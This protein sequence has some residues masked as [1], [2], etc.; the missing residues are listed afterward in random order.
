MRGIGGEFRH[1]GNGD[2]CVKPETT[3]SLS[4]EDGG[5]DWSDEATSQGMQGLPATTRSQKEASGDGG[6]VKTLILEL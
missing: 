1:R 2:H 3:G 5:R 4:H 6:P